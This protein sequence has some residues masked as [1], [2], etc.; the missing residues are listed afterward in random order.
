VALPAGASAEAASTAVLLLAL[1]EVGAVRAKSIATVSLLIEGYQLAVDD[2]SIW[3]PAKG[4][5][6]VRKLLIEHSATSRVQRDLSV[7]LHCLHTESIEL[8]FIRPLR[9]VRK[10]CDGQALH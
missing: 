2:C 4:G 6:D 9:A 10:L 5:C 1:P 3:N 7:G 8:Y